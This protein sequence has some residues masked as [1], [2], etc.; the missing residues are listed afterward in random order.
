MAAAAETE[1]Y[2]RV[3]GC[4]IRADV[5]RAPTADPAPTIIWLHGGALMWGSCAYMANLEQ[6]AF[7]NQ[8]GYTVVALDYRLAPET[9]IAEILADVVDGIGWV[10][11][12]GAERFGVDPAR[13]ALLGH[14]AGGYLALLSATTLTPPVQAIVSMYGYGDIAAR[15]YTKPDPHYLKGQRVTE[16]E[17]LAVVGQDAT[18]NA[19]RE[20]GL[21]YRY[22]RQQGFWPTAVT[23]LD[24]ATQRELLVRFCPEHVITKQHPPTFL[25]H[26]DEDTD[27]PHSLT[28]SMAAAFK[29]ARVMHDLMILRGYGHVFD[30]HYTDPP[31]V[32]AFAAIIKFLNRHLKKPP[33]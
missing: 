5:Y 18:S 27:V 10:R 22:C 2:K 9:K 15:W 1:I 19:G 21:Y 12:V 31:V 33:V 17:A 16:A 29:K 24:P 13:I 32:A 14:S 8:A 28:M 11:T 7:Y 20:R 4:D 30:D 23:G 3:G 26:G 25:L 6:V